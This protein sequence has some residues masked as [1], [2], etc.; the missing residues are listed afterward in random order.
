MTGKEI[1]KAALASNGWSQKRL[2]DEIG[3]T[4]SDITGYLNRGKGDIRLDYFV[5]MLDAMGYKVVIQ[6][7]KGDTDKWC[8]EYD[9]KNP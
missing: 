7:K 2:A 6:D 3:K 5:E 8:M 4:Q 1:I 9:K